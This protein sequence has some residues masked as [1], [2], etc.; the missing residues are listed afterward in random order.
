MDETR[1]AKSI[2]PGSLSSVLDA[3]HTG[4]STWQEGWILSALDL[5]ET[6]SL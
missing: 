1:W 3:S 4:L 5:L 2:C 6:W